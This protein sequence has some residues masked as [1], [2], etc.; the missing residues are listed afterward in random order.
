MLEPLLHHNAPYPY[1]TTQ[2]ELLTVDLLKLILHHELKTSAMIVVF[3]AT[4]KVTFVK[5][6][7]IF[8]IDLPAAR[9]L[10]LLN[11]AVSGPATCSVP[12]L[13]RGL[14]KQDH[15]VVFGFDFL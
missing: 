4:S 10:T 13:H 3:P 7:A 2:L 8:P 12:I 15:H 9:A 1:S 5:A 6:Q 11:E 14:L